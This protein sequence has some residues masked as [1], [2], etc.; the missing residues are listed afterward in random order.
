MDKYRA[1]TLDGENCNGM[2]KRVQRP[3]RKTQS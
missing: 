2:K 3:Y 1:Y